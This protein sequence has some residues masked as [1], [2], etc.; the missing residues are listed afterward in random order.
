MHASEAQEPAE[1]PAVLLQE[2]ERLRR[3]T[4]SAGR[5][6][7]F[8]LTL[9]G[10]LVLLAAPLYVTVV[11]DDTDVI[12]YEIVSPLVL[13]FGGMF[14]TYPVATAVYWFAALIVGFVG[15]GLWYRRQGQRLGLRRPVLAFV[16]TGLALTLGLVVLQQVPFV[17]IPLFWLTARGTVATVVIALALLVLARL[18]R[19]AALAWISVAFLGVAVL[20]STY[21]VENL[22]FRMGIPSG[23][24]AGTVAV[25]LPGLV[26]VVSGL[27]ARSRSAAASKAPVAP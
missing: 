11:T 21:N 2:V 26:L 22:L 8:P 15:S 16:V 10:V 6:W 27:V 7:W 5:H 24:W 1:S 12:T 23:A 20:V 18:E 13:A 25:V 19:S 4:R 14:A 9:F 3:T 17:D